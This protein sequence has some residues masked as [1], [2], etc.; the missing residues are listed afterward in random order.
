[1]A[2][3]RP[4]TADDVA[5]ITGQQAA[6]TRLHEDYDPSFYAPSADAFTEFS[7]YIISKM[8]D[9]DFRILVAEEEGVR[10]GYCMG[11]LTTRPPIYAKRRVGYI[12]HINVDSQCR[13]RGIA[14]QLIAAM[15]SLFTGVGVDFI[16]IHVDAENSAALRLVESLGFA[17]RWT[18][19]HKEAH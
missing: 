6:M 8:D 11:W 18:A 17:A 13:G 7:Q 12:S 4:Y 10:A 3:I 1:M 15:L 16:E 14:S 2:V 19:L 9:Q 5:W